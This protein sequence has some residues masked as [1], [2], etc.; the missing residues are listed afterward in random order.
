MKS[1]APFIVILLLVVGTFAFYFAQGLNAAHDLRIRASGTVEVTEVQ[2]A[3]QIEGRIIGLSLD[4]GDFVSQGQLVCH[5]SLDGLDSDIRAQ[6]AALKRE[7]EALREL[8]NGARPE[9]IRKADAELKGK[10]AQWQQA[11]R[12]A[13]RFAQLLSEDAVSKK[14]AE[15]Y[16][17]NARVLGEAVNSARQQY[18]LLKRGP[19]EEEISRQRETIRQV[20]AQLESA[21]LRLSYKKVFSPISGSVLSKNFESGEV[22]SAGTP[23]LTVGNTGDKWVKVYI[24][25]TQL[26]KIRI[27]QTAE[28]YADSPPETSFPGRVKAVAREAEFNPRLSLTQ[29]ERANQV[30]WV[31]VGVSGDEGRM[32]PGMPADVVFS[33]E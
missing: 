25:A 32:K 18:L 15:L 22:I 27:G 17:E 6:E 31:K 20:E 3:P 23:I 33:V 2:I 4:E 29:Q 8:L 11:R 13:A 5:L 19:R 28:V 1:K 9:E 26:D 10:Q 7:N 21:R 16:E 14:E 12:D 30:F 24:P